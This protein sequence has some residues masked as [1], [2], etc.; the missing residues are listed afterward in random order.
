MTA[1][2]DALTALLEGCP[3]PIEVVGDGDLADALRSATGGGAKVEEPGTIVDTTGTPD[4]LADAL[5]RVRTLG[6]V[7]LAGP[8]P[9]AGVDL[10]V[11]SDLHVRGLTLLGV[12][13]DD[14]ISER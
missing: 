8:V 12:E 6:T 5:V 11:Y 13:V 7:V 14:S 2:R 1:D 3:T 10:D 9:Q 4:A